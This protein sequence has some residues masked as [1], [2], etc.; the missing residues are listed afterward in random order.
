MHWQNAIMLGLQN[1]PKK[2]IF[3]HIY[4]TGTIFAKGKKKKEKQ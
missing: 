3:A 4:I 2:Y 1:L